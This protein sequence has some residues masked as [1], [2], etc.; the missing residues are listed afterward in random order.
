MFEWM[1]ETKVID[2]KITVDM[3]HLM[4]LMYLKIR[5]CDRK[6]KSDL[7]MY[8]CEISVEKFTGKV[9]SHSNNFFLTKQTAKCMRSNNILFCF[10]FITISAICHLAYFIIII[11]LCLLFHYST[12]NLCTTSFRFRSHNIMC[13]EYRVLI[14]I[15]YFLLLF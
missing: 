10:F 6:R 4:T 11:F 7:Y 8:K 5:H 1:I 9:L 3:I 12:I 14:R 15:S 2:V 13:L